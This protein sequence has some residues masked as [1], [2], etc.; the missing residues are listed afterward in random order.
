VD[1][2]PTLW[3]LIQAFPLYL[4]KGGI[5]QGYLQGKIK[6]ITSN[7]AGVTLYSIIRFF[8]LVGADAC[9]AERLMSKAAEINNPVI[10]LFISFS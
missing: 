6:S 7:W 8:D 3:K 1:S 5:C 10:F 2:Q 4:Q 9:K